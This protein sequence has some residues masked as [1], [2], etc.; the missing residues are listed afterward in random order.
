MII[1]Y[2]CAHFHLQQRQWRPQRFRNGSC[3]ERCY[4][5]IVINYDFWKLHRS[6]SD[7]NRILWASVYATFQRIYT[8]CQVVYILHQQ[9]LTH[10]IFGHLT[11]DS[12]LHGIIDVEQSPTLYT[13]TIDR[14]HFIWVL[15]TFF[16]ASFINWKKIQRFDFIR[17]IATRVAFTSSPRLFVQLFSWSAFFL[18]PFGWAE[19]RISLRISSILILFNV[20]GVTWQYLTFKPNRNDYGMAGFKQSEIK[21]NTMKWKQ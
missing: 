2:S 20:F 21:C 6:L 10:W 7:V 18:D 17:L 5:C 11:S 14:F 4:S 16:D 9:Q 8:K 19:S 13:L 12:C 15:F 1:Y 3:F